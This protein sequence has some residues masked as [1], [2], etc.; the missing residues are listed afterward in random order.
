MRLKFLSRLVAEDA[1]GTTFVV[2][3]VEP[4]NR[5]IWTQPMEESVSRRFQRK[6]LLLPNNDH[7]VINGFVD[8]LL[9]RNHDPDPFLSKLMN[10]V[11]N[12]HPLIEAV[13]I[14]FSGHWPLTL[15]PDCIWL[16][17]AQGF[18]H[19][20]AENSETLRS[21]LVRHQGVKQ[22]YA[23]VDGLSLKSFAKPLP[24]FQLRSVTRPILF[25]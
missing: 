7:P 11:S 15:S 1:S 17:I 13:H 16:V 6:V 23:N 9:Q 10:Y 5:R 8:S 3:H 22:L 21:S 25:C 4:A 2:D 24:T 14:A 19:H 18:S 20:I 12:K